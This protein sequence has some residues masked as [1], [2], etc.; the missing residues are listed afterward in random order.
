MPRI[1]LARTPQVLT[2]HPAPAV[3]GSQPPAF[4]VP[5]Q[6]FP[7]AVAKPDLWRVPDLCTGAT[8]VKGATFS[9]EIHSTSIYR[10]FDP[11]RH[12]DPPPGGARQD[13]KPH[14]QVFR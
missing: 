12:R 2:A 1:F 3:S 5:R 8:D 4:F 11:Q 14:R 6:R 13:E 7:N 10:R 9:E